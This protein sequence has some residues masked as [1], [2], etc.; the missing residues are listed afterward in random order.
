MRRISRHSSLAALLC[1][2]ATQRVHAQSD[3]LALVDDQS[4]DAPAIPT[5]FMRYPIASRNAGQMGS[6]YAVVTLDENGRI[7][8]GSSRIISSSQP[9]FRRTVRGWLDSVSFR[10]P[11]RKGE[12]VRH[13]VCLP[14]HFII[15]RD[16]RQLPKVN[17]PKPGP[18]D[19][20]DIGEQQ[21]CERAAVMSVVAERLP[22]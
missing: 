9:D 7:E 15:S 4:V 11:R 3:T 20:R 17:L 22:F 14:I 8:P 18:A 21:L 1:L 6:V 10:P 12:P 2:V 16:A 19:Y 13:R 5:S